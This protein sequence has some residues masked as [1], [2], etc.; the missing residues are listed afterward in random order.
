MERLNLKYSTA[1]FIGLVLFA[2]GFVVGLGVARKV[3]P[4]VVVPT[5]SI[6]R[7]TVMVRD[8]IAGQ[9]L[10]PV[11]REVI[12]RDTLI[13]QSKQDTTY[14]QGDTI[15]RDSVRSP[16]AYYL[17]DGSISVPIE[18]RTYST[19]DYKAV[20][21]GWHPKLDSMTVYPKRTTITETV[22]KVAPTPRRLWTIAAGPSATYTADG[23][24]LPGVSV[25]LGLNIK[26]W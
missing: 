7:D 16:Q 10:P 6:Q 1:A 21:S 5:I 23:K 4:C 15:K 25:V 11:V 8:T 9:I 12:R 19:D 14:K 17:P 20:I 3:N 22:T 26:S 18:Q 13:L 24:F 2:I